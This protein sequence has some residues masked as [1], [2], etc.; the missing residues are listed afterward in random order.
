MHKTLIKYIL[1]ERKC[2]ELELALPPLT[3]QVKLSKI[4][5]SMH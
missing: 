5:K 3:G 4:D 1:R 2:S